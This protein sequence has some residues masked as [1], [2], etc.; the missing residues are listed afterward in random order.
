MADSFENMIN[1]IAQS[2]QDEN[3]SD[4]LSQITDY[5]GL[6]SWHLFLRDRVGANPEFFEFSIGKEEH[7]EV[8]IEA[9]ANTV[10]EPEYK[11]KSLCLWG[12][13]IQEG[14]MQALDPVYGLAPDTVFGFTS[15][16]MQPVN[17]VEYVLLIANQ[18]RN[19][20]P[21]LYSELLLLAD[22]LH[23]SFAKSQQESGD[24]KIKLGKREH[25]VLS[26]TSQGKTSFEIAKILGLSENTINNY[27]LNATKKLGA[28]NRSHAVSK[29]IHLG[30]I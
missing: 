6:G 1:A 30:L 19:C 20:E 22:A 23:N 15:I 10:S 25:Q 27:V 26:W 3:R 21:L 4:M 28:S 17:G 2:D 5:L 13:Q 16:L 18:D 24:R 11:Y 29:A 9:F 14:K 12:S 7:N 8:L